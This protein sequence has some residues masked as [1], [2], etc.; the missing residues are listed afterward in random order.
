MTPSRRHRRVAVHEAG[1]ALVALLFNDVVPL[2]HVS[3]RP[4][5]RSSGRCLVD[6]P[7]ARTVWTWRQAEAVARVWLAGEVADT[8]MHGCEPLPSAPDRSAAWRWA[9]RVHSGDRAAASTWLANERRA[10]E[11]TLSRPH[12]RRALEALADALERE[13]YLG[14][15]RVRSI[16]ERA[17]GLTAAAAG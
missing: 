9:L 10:V 17:F 5:R 12:C 3:I 14:A 16:C 13:D 6:F 2:R 7:P 11:A 4:L 1:H 15:R 8:I